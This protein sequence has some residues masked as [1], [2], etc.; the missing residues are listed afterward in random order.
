MH[1]AKLVCLQQFCTPGKMSADINQDF[2]RCCKRKHSFWDDPIGELLLYLCEP[3]PWIRKIV[4]I[5]YNAKAFYS[6]FILN[7]ALP[8]K[9]KPELILDVL[10]FAS[11]KIKHKLFIDSVSYLP[12]PLSKLPDAFG[13]SITKSW[14]PNYYNKNM[15]LD[16]VGP[17]PDVSYFGVYEMSISERREF[18]TWYDD[19][20]NKVLDNKL[21]LEKYYQYDVTVFRQAC[22]IFRSE[23]MEI[24]NIGVFS[25]I[26]HHCNHV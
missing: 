3:R 9:W 16:Y 4:A 13:L 25:W 20:K 1:V 19:Q 2:E 17:I 24:R 8:M 12:M 18:M 6:K 23:F 5:A 15:N 21:V 11:M 7:R 22:Q 14:Y 26:V 10:K